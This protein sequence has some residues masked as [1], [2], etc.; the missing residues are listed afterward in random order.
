MRD[1]I[2]WVV[3]MEVLIEAVTGARDWTLAAAIGSCWIIKSR[4]GR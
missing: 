2:V 3:G 4:V 1:G